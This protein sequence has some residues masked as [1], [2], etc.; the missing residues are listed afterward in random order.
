MPQLVECKTGDG[1][2]SALSRHC[3]FLY[4]PK[5]NKLLKLGL[6]YKMKMYDKTKKDVCL[7][8]IVSIDY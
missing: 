2:T 8:K 7:L 5:T 6:K 3:H 1:R 4:Q